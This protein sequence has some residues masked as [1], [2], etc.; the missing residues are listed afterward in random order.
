MLV[1]ALLLP[2]SPSPI[3]FRG[4]L[5]FNG[6]STV[7]IVDDDP[8][9][10]SIWKDRIM[11]SNENI[12][13]EHFFNAESATSWAVQNREAASNCL[14]LTDFNLNSQT[15]TGLTVLERF[16]LKHP[17]AVMVTNAFNDNDLRRRCEKMNVKM[18]P[19]SLMIA[20][21]F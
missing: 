13:V 4:D 15:G 9:I 5:R 17:S 12:V 19:K 11:R 2:T 16:G 3:W 14:L 6:Y 10:H 1:Y 8:T 7:V 20:A 18:M 21:T